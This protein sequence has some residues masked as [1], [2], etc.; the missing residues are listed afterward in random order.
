MIEVTRVHRRRVP[1]ATFKAHGEIDRFIGMRGADY[2]D[3]R[4]HQFGHGERMVGS[5]FDEQ[6]ARVGRHLEP[7]GG[8]DF[9]RVARGQSHRARYP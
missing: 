8:G 3:H 2:G 5:G 4:H 6:E 1:A 9:R 7:D